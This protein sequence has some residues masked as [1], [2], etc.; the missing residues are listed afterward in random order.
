[1]SFFIDRFNRRKSPI[2]L[3]AFGAALLYAVIFGVLYALLAEPLYHAVSLGS[4]TATTVCHT[5]IIAVIG[6]AVC[7][8]LFLLK[9]KRVAPYGFFGL[10]VVLGMFYAAAILLEG[11]A[12]SLML[13]L[14]TIYGLAPVLVGNAVTWPIY[15]K[16]KRDNPALNHRKTITEE[17]QEAVAKESA[18]KQRSAAK[19]ASKQSGGPIPTPEAK[20]GPDE[21]P[22]PVSKERPEPS[23]D[24]LFGPEAD[25]SPMVSRSAQEEA[26]LFYEDDEDEETGDD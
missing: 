1:M 18:K 12:R 20:L 17:L 7:C 21:G 8:L 2:A 3:A 16:M 6:T 11:D 19:R 13:Y 15:L 24:A 4:P 9:D 5:V 22:P 14:I 26:M 25:R 10:A 23:G